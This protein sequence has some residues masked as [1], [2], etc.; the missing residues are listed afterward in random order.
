MIFMNKKGSD[1]GAWLN[2][3]S[4]MSGLTADLLNDGEII[5]QKLASLFIYLKYYT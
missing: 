5:K 2:T 3:L 1:T 4:G